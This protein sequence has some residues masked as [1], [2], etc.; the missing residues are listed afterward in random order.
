MRLLPLTV[1]GLW[2]C[3]C[4][5]FRP[6]YLHRSFRSSNTVRKISRRC[7]SSA[8]TTASTR[9]P[10][11][12]R[13]KQ[14]NRSFSQYESSR[15]TRAPLRED[16]DLQSQSI[17]DLEA[18]LEQS[19]SR[20]RID[21]SKTV[22]ILKTLLQKH[23]VN[24]TTR[25]YKAYLLANVDRQH[26]SAEN[27]RSL[28]G[29]MA[30]QGITADSATLH[31]ALEVLAVHPDYL[32]RQEVIEALRA[33]WLS[34]SPVGWHH[35]IAGLLREDQL[36]LALDRLDQMEGKGI[37]LEQWLHSLLVYKLCDADEFTEALRLIRSRSNKAKSISS[38]MWL[39][40][41]RAAIRNS[42]YETVRYVWNNAVD[43]GYQDLSVPDCRDVLGFAS[44]HGD[45]GFAESVFRHLSTLQKH[46]T[47][48]DYEK[49]VQVYAQNADVKSA[50]EIICQMHKSRIPIE[51]ECTRP[52][53]Q[54]METKLS[55]PTILWSEI[56]GLRKR[57]YEI[58]TTLAN[59]VIQHTE[60]LFQRG[61]LSASRAIDL[62][63]YIYKDLFDICTDGANTETFNSLISLCHQTSKPGICT[64]FVKE[65]A[66]LDVSPDQR[67]LE[68]LILSCLDCGND[69]S[70]SKYLADLQAQGWQ[71]SDLVKDRIREIQN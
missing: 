62:A 57:G 42:H 60:V 48:Y 11:G 36:E 50:F 29:E 23:R 17:G 27:V 39:Y 32:L 14:G 52:V 56:R 51:S 19:S 31:A 34:L 1:D 13:H 4:P 10:L 41:L 18:L 40:L 16:E 28:L 47:S 59:I 69:S 65:M 61:S 15:L 64:F 49:L 30:R 58:P 44:D 71:L 67:T 9:A 3:L 66:S 46:P 24:P 6:T 43:L 70:A 63:V 53:L 68:T 55:D 2:Y 25:H 12:E 35:V 45:I 20:R 26:G 21:I 7:L 5:S 22:A 37:P 54:S 8:S 38:A 33:R